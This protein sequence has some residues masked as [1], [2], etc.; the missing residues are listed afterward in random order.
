MKKSLYRLS[1]FAVIATALALSPARSFAQ[2]KKDEKAPAPKAENANRPLPFRGKVDAIDKTAKTVKVGER[3]F[4]VTAETRIMKNEKPAKLDDAAVGE[5][6]R[7]SYRKTDDGKLNAV[8]LSFGVKPA[9]AEGAPAKKQPN[10]EPK[11]A[12]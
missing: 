12:Q 9:E 4:H 2:E 7:I 11:A 10:A 6:V 5:E 3:V 1:L 8:S